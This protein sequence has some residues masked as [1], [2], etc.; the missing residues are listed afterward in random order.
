MIPV[1][2]VVGKIDDGWTVAT[3]LLFH[4]RAAVG[5]ASPY[6]S[7]RQPGGGDTAREHLA[8]HRPGDESPR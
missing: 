5:G 6:T 2:N 4:E 8:R 7:G 3:R 1:E